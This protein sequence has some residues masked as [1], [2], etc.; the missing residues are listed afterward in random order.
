LHPSG[1]SQLPYCENR[2]FVFVGGAFINRG[3]GLLALGHGVWL[4]H[5]PL[6]ALGY[7]W[8]EACQVPMLGYRTGWTFYAWWDIFAVSEAGDIMVVLCACE[9]VKLHR[10]SGRTCA[11]A[12][13]A[14]NSSMLASTSFQ[15]AFT[16]K[17][18]AL[19]YLLFR[20]GYVILLPGR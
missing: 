16:F 11:L 14:C 1:A 17:L 3:W 4:G 12:S 7:R 13:L 15:L 20:Y 18:Q 2:F 19:N 5:V 8:G 9:Q 10:Y 6:L